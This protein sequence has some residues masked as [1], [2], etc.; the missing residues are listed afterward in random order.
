M[1]CPPNI[2]RPAASIGHGSASTVRAV[3]RL[4]HAPAATLRITSG[5]GLFVPGP[6]NLGWLA[7]PSGIVATCWMILSTVT[8]SLPYEYPITAENFK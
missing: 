3:A 7:Y 4:R 5:R 2:S 1:C 6:F 8:F